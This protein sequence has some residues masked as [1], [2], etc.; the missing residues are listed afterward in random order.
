M[1]LGWNLSDHHFTIFLSSQANISQIVVHSDLQ[2]SKVKKSPTKQSKVFLCFFSLKNSPSCRQSN[3]T[4]SKSLK[5]NGLEVG[6]S[7]KGLQAF[8][9][10][11]P[12]FESVDLQ[13]FSKGTAKI[14]CVFVFFSFH[15]PVFGNLP[16]N[17]G[18]NKKCS[19]PPTRLNPT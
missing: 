18:E 3:N 6:P 17:R 19:K 13:S 11:C 12:F 10:S 1:I 9:S 14:M 16:P 2:W 8:T 15:P 5:K 7:K 4:S